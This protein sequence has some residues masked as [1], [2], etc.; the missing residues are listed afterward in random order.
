MTRRQWLAP[1]T[2]ALLAFAATVTSLGHDFTF[3][4]RYVILGNGRVHE[5]KNLWHLF[6]ETYWPRYLGA[7]GYRPVVMALFTLQWVAAGGAPWLFHLVNI[8]LTVGASVAVYWC[9]A[10]ILPRR[11]AWVAA[12]LFAVHPVHVE[13][14]GN[15]VGQSELIV[16]LCLALAVGIYLRARRG[17][18]PSPRA[19]C[20]I[21]SL[22]TVALLSKE[23]AIVLPALIA[24]AEVTVVRDGSWKQRLRKL[25]PFALALIAVSLAWFLVRDRVQGNLSGFAPFPVFRFLRMS[26]MDRAGMM[27]TEIPRVARLLVFPTRLSGDYSPTEV[28]VTK[29]FDVA[30]IPGLVICLG[31]VILAIALRRRAPVISFGLS[32]LLVS[33]LPVS[34][35]LVPTGFITAERTLF[36]PSVGVVLV[37]GALATAVEARARR[38]AQRTAL[39]AVALL[40]TLGLARSIDRQRVWKN[41]DVFFAQLL[42]DA[43]NSYRAHFLHGR[44]VG[45]RSRLREMEL[46]YR[47]AIKLFPYD[48][49]MMMAIA[50]D[51]HRAGFCEP[52][53]ALLEWSYTVEPEVIDGRYEY[54]QCLNKM[55]RWTQARVAG[56]DG[57][58][59]VRPS[60]VTPLRAAVASA[61]SA[62]GRRKAP[63]DTSSREVGKV[64]RQPQN[65][66]AVRQRGDLSHSINQ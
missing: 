46:E 12:A 42:K 13:A 55:R 64:L 58:R 51:Y 56:L 39:A 40:V 4:D 48:V 57:L 19:A 60:L 35:L 38:G 20:A 21:L 31:V 53:V 15:V 6:A 63:R 5:L 10:A 54:V 3:D 47:R 61:D 65:P 43:P 59:Y 41:N 25:R 22:Y 66:L 27:M 37:A 28:L 24:V 9:A 29:G 52:A 45:E 26:A 17:G 23:H 2:I 1:A 16:A 49:S 14:T 50:A 32:W 11:G 30:Q 34:N 18:F 62:L 33:Y 8:L 7:D 44:L 36:L